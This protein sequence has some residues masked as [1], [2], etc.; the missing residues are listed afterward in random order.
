M[1]LD[2]RL[3]ALAKAAGYDEWQPYQVE[4]FDLVEGM[5]TDTPRI[6]LYY[7]TGAGKTATA[8]VCMAI[9]GYEDVLVIAPPS[10]HD[11]WVELGDKLGIKVEAMSHAKFRMK[12]TKLERDKAV[13]ADEMHLFG[14][15]TGKGWQKLDRLAKGLKAPLILA[16]AT[17]SYNDADRVYCVHHILDPVALHGGFLE[18]LYAN[19]VTQQNPFSVTPDVLRFRHY[20]TA[21]EYLD[22]LPGV[23]YLPDDLVYQIKDYPLAKKIPHAMEGYGYDERNHRVIAS[24]IEE[25]HTQTYQSLVKDDGTLFKGPRDWLVNLL[26]DAVSPVL[27]YSDHSTIAE[28]IAKTLRMMDLEC[29]LVTGKSTTKSKAYIIDQ[30][31]QGKTDILVGTATLATGTD[32]L[33]K[34]CDWL[35]IFDDTNDDALRRQLIGRIMPRGKGGDA[36]TKHVHRL[37][38]Q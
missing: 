37:V 33:D 14:G 34:V 25:T 26:E 17:P 13:I 38:L 31:R 24:I 32:G 21:A 20:D 15:H 18:F 35:L 30:F 11:A 19:C 6:C 5:L 8:L 3:K 29:A 22:A 2:A 9:W 36:S 27:I 16:S 23:M 10:T 1:S 7:K 28:A 12:S 4:T